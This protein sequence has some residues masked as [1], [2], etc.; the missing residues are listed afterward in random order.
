[1][2]QI[3]HGQRRPRHCHG[4]AAFTTQAVGALHASDGTTVAGQGA[5]ALDLALPTGIASAVDRTAVDTG[6]GHSLSTGGQ[7]TIEHIAPLEVARAELAGP[8]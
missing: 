1:M 2:L 3:R 8:A 4:I 7:V 5:V 6:A